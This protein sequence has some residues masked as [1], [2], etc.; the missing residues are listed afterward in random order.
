M[1]L[2]EP[3]S[4]SRGAAHLRYSLCVRVRR[5]ASGVRERDRDR[6][7]RGE[8]DGLFGAVHSRGRKHP[9]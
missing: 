3:L 5:V 7:G 8:G 4:N 2:I 1:C 9:V 6:I